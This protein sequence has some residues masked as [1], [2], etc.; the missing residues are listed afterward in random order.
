MDVVIVR[1]IDRLTRNL[2]DWN[3]FEKVCVRHGVRLSAYTGGDLDLSTAE[4][5]YYG[6]ME[7]LRARRES[8]V[9]SARVR[10][11]QDREARKGRRLS[12]GQRWFGYTRIY[13]NPDEPNPKKRHILR[14]E[15]NPVEAD[16]I[17]D[18]A[19]R[20]LEHGE[21]VASI[22]R[23]WTARGIKPVA[24][25]QWWP[26]SIVGTLTSA[27]LAGLLEWQGKKYPATQWPAIIDVDTHERLVKLFADPARRKHVV[28]APAHLLS[29][30]ATCPKCGRGLHYRRYA[31]RRADS[32]ACVVGPKGCGGT[33]IKA[34]LL[35]EYVTGAVLD[36]LESPRV[37]EALREGEDQ[38]APRRAELLGQIRDA[39]ER[40]DE[41]RRDYSAR[42]IDR[43]DWLDIRQRTEDD[44]STARRE[45]DRLT[46]SATVMSDIPPSERVRDAWESWNTDR[47]RAAIRAVLH[48]VI[49][50]PLP[51]ARHPTA[52]TA[53]TKPSAGNANGS[54]A[55]ARRIRL[56]HLSSRRKRA[57]ETGHGDRLR[58]SSG[59]CCRV[60]FIL[61]LSLGGRGAGMSRRIAASIATAAG[62]SIRSGSPCRV[63]ERRAFSAPACRMAARSSALILV[64]GRWSSVARPHPL[65]RS[66][67]VIVHVHVHGACASL[68]GGPGRGRT[69]GH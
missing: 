53:R 37:Q 11:A 45:Y 20:V 12:G 16:A 60:P 41:A 15:I 47:R 36:A 59:L 13:A 19:M 14:E 17:R 39:Q 64:G 62:S 2:T 61:M 31:Q 35:E 26:T 5:A 63:R 55:A 34:G 46:G 10:E 28:R 51:P 32:Y 30:I 52:A 8:A 3:A 1:D 9:K 66:R 50:K 7:T 67:S 68:R 42:V 43:A 69:G 33:A 38:H 18:A 44:I 22:V 40:R 57:A 49:I 58:R 48:R 23:D 4:G 24:A 27:R 56:A 65:P 25:K 6:G 21:S 29:G 54:P